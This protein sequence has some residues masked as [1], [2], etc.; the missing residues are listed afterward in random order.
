M[1]TTNL[2]ELKRLRP[3]LGLVAPVDRA[4]GRRRPHVDPSGPGMTAS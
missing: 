2:D 3:S 4:G 1:G